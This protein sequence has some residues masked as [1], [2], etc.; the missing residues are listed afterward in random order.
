MN[1]INQ[2]FRVL[3]SIHNH[4]CRQLQH[5]VEKKHSKGFEALNAKLLQ[6]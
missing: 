2:T 5:S 6:V 4:R 3:F 1:K